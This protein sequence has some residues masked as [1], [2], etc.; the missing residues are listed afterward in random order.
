MRAVALPGAGAATQNGC[1]TP[2]VEQQQALLAVLC[3]FNNG[4][5]QR[6]CQN[7]LFGLALHI[8]QS[9]GGQGSTAHATG[10]VESQVTPLPGGMPGFE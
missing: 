4:L 2:P 1:I 7:G 5:D 8:D 10:H 3:S 9:Q 6:L